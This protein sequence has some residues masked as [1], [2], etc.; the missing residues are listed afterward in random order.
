MQKIQDDNRGL[1]KRLTDGKH[2]LE[3]FT[4]EFKELRVEIR[5]LNDFE[6]NDDKE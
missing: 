2:G 1:E 5:T 6:V 3:K 4:T